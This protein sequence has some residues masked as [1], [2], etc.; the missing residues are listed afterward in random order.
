MIP[1]E[2]DTTSIQFGILAAWTVMTISACSWVPTGPA[3]AE[4]AYCDEP[5]IERC[6]AGV[7]GAIPVARLVFGRLSKNRE[8]DTFCS[9]TV[10]N[11]IG[12]GQ[13]IEIWRNSARTFTALDNQRELRI[14]SAEERADLSCITA[15]TTVYARSCIESAESGWFSSNVDVCT[16]YYSIRLPDDGVKESNSRNRVPAATKL[17]PYELTCVEESIAGV[18][19]CYDW[20]NLEFLLANRSDT[21]V[22]LTLDIPERGTVA[23][24]QYYMTAG[25]RVRVPSEDVAEGDLMQARAWVGYLES[26]I[27]RLLGDSPDVEATFILQRTPTVPIDRSQSWQTARLTL[28]VVSGVACELRVQYRPAGEGEAA[29]SRSNGSDILCRN[30]SSDQIEV[31]FYALEETAAGFGIDF[32]LADFFLVLEDEQL[33]PLSSGVIDGSPYALA[34][35]FLDPLDGRFLSTSSRGFHVALEPAGLTAID[36]ALLPEF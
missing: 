3:E 27:N 32:E 30:G 9:L 34:V 1:R 29:T 21:A 10:E 26:V 14:R 11:L 24:D 17:I 4:L 5:Q 23:V 16:H 6:D 15:G 13:R 28:P 33:A 2:K 19:V 31:H 25:Q 35:R 18:Q 20:D 8:P 7:E 22:H 36:G 12:N